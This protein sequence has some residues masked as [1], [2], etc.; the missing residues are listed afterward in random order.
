VVVL[1]L[2]TAGAFTPRSDFE[3]RGTS[4][5]PALP[6]GRLLR[7]PD[8]FRARLEDRVLLGL[9][10][11]ESDPLDHPTA[12]L[13]EWIAPSVSMDSV[14]VRLEIPLPDFAPDLTEKN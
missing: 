5:A 4:V 8:V 11:V 6:L 13:P 14:G 12:T 7:I 10:R 9:A 2:T 3:T 1:A